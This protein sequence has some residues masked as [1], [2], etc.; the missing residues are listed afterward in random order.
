MLR[1]AD[2]SV[3]APGFEGK[4]ATIV[5]GECAREADAAVHQDTNEPPTP[6]DAEGARR[7]APYCL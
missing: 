6:A 5:G 3:K 2:G 7:F 1:A 4:S